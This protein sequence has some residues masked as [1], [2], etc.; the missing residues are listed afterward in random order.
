M[1]LNM[2]C[3]EYQEDFNSITEWCDKIYEKRFSAYFT[4]QRELSN[5][6]KS[7]TKPISD[8]EL[9]FILMEVP[10]NMFDVSEALNNFQMEYEVLKLEVKGKETKL[11]KDSTESTETKRKE[12]AAE[13]VIGDK[14]LIL[15]YNNIL[16]RV[17]KEISYS[18]ELIMAAKK[19]YDRRTQ[20]ECA[21]P[22]SEHVSLSLP[23]YQPATKQYV[24]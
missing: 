6:L 1:D 23:E 15:A 13:Q 18:R 19:L 17:E 9:E 3:D 8:D 24:R 20:T 7:K 22:I 5:R 12:F 11:A 4:D 14:I 21:N 10:L 16:A 2:I